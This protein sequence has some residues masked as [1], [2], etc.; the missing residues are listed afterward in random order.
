MAIFLPLLGFASLGWLLV[1]PVYSTWGSSAA[2]TVLLIVT[3]LASTLREIGF[4]SWHPLLKDIIPQQTVSV[5]FGRLRTIFHTSNLILMVLLS[6]FMGKQP[7]A[8]KFSMIFALVVVSQFVRAHL[9][10]HIPDPAGPSETPV[11]SLRHNLAN[12]RRP[13][14]D[15]AFLE[16]CAVQLTITFLMSAAQP[17]Y[18]PYLS[19][20]RGFPSS[21]T[22]LG[23]AGMSAG[24]MLSLTTWG[25]LARERGPRSVLVSAAW[26]LVGTYALLAAVPSH[27]IQPALSVA[28]AG[29]VFIG[30]GV[31]WSGIG[32]TITAFKFELVP[33]EESPFYMG[34]HFVVVSLGTIS[35]ALLGGAVSEAT[36]G[37]TVGTGAVVV[38]SYQAIILGIGLV[39]AVATLF[40]RRSM[41]HIAVQRG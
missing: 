18:V 39:L 8:W 34:L 11:T 14:D 12:L 3:V 15:G 13:L 32:L 20:S 36:I 5:F 19:H 29:L 7:P 33:Q 17:I 30:V 10:H 31:G 16:F 38:D 6:A 4:A 27:D 41:S 40:I 26:L 1:E 9:V 21:L 35:G 22:V 28:V 37:G 23:L 2:V 24:S 25:R